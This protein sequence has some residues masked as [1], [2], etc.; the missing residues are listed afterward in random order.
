M[1]GGW[2]DAGDYLKLN[3]PLAPGVGLMAWGLLEFKDAY[4]SAG[5]LTNALNSLRLITDYLS[6]S[7]DWTTGKYS[8]Q[9]GDP[10]I[11]HGYW[12]RPEEQTSN[13]PHLL[14]D[15][16]MAACDLYGGVAGTLAASSMVFRDN[17]DPAYADELMRV[18]KELYTWGTEKEG[19]YSNFYTQQTKSIYPSTDWEDN[20]A[21]ASGWMYH[22][23]SDVTY[24]DRAFPYWTRGKSDYY[25]SWDSVWAP[26]AAHMVTLAAKGTIVPGIDTYRAYMANFT[27]AWVYA[28]GYQSIVKTPLGMHYPSWNEWANLAFSSTSSSI[29][30]MIAKY[31]GDPTARALQIDFARKQIDYALGSG[32]RSYVIGYGNNPP[33]SPHHASSSCPNLPAPCNWDNFRSLDP[34]PQ[35]LFGALVGGPAGVRK[36]SANP[37]DSYIDKR[38][39]YVT[40]EVALD[41]NSGF[42]TALAGL[43]ALL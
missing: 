9:I 19:K 10:N 4:Q 39:N 11:D 20:M 1:V 13:R 12:G 31:E 23:T 34:N 2:Y 35:T 8:A 33:R 3:F 5:E 25:P 26:H 7:L 6:R 43:Y 17:G 32:I 27:R 14:Y 40:N 42:T 18:A 22:A 21:W 30:L 41:Y 37:D 28:D 38:S 36:N 29:L 24:L 16:T 15:R